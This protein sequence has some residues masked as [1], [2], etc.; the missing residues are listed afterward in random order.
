V[1]DFYSENY[2]TLKL[3]IIEDTTQLKDL[4]CSYI[5]RINIMKMVILLKVIYRFN[6]MPIKI[7]TSFSQ[8]YKKNPKIHTEAQEKKTPPSKRACCN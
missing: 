1:K 5:S 6:V 3:K 4:S 7:P 8:K 2:K